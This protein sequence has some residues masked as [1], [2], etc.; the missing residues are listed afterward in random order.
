MKHTET[1][2]TPS[3]FTSTVS[4]FER[5][6]YMDDTKSVINV[7]DS[8]NHRTFSKQ[9]SNQ[10]H[11]LNSSRKPAISMLTRTTRQQ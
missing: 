10:L 2:I 1:K 8:D 9:F 7:P 4:F 3:G 6:F 5:L 11:F